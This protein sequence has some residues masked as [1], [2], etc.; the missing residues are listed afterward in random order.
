MISTGDVGR[1]IGAEVVDNAGESIGPVRTVY[2][3]ANTGEPQWVVV[4][5]GPMHFEQSFVPLTGARLDGGRLVVATDKLHAKATPLIDT[6]GPLDQESADRLSAHYGLSAG[7]E[8]AAPAANDDAMTRS[9]ER[10][11]VGKHRE[12]VGKV[13]LRKYVVTEERQITVPVRREEI[14]LEEV[15]PGETGPADAIGESEA[16]GESDDTTLTL[17][18]ER[19]VVTTETVPVEQVRLS[20]QTVRETRTVSG[21]VR[22]EQID[23]ETD[24]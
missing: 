20:K 6:D 19:P 14:R 23:Y 15:P 5:T 17:H 10:L 16:I 24:S 22:K 7:D 9:E 11:V 3:D 12:P 1:L 8:T 2:A 21:D 13:R 18:A 4:Q